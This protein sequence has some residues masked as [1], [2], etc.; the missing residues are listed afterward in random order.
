MKTFYFQFTTKHSNNTSEHSIFSSNPVS[1]L[2]K[3]HK[4]MQSRRE[5]DPITKDEHL[6]YGPEDY[7]I[8]RLFLRY[9]DEDKNWIESDYDLP[10]C[11]NPLIPL[12]EEEEPQGARE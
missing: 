8:H 6:L 12:E 5:A 7:K 3:F 9:Q 1:A 4:Y 10:P 2:D 11:A